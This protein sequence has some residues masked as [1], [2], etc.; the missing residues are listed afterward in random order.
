MPI[1]EKRR[2]YE[3]LVRFDDEGGLQG[4][5]AKDMLRYH[6]SESGETSKPVE[7]DPRPVTAAEFGELLGP[8]IAAGIESLDAREK[9]LAADREQ[10]QATL[11]DQVDA[12]KAQIAEDRAALAAERARFEDDRARLVSA[13][14]ALVGRA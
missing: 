14:A 9:A 2:L 5:H 8:A 12:A 1:E 10:A 4:A 13:A 7:S 3:L 6:N 11:K